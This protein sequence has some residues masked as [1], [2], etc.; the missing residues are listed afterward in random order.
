MEFKDNFQV[1]IIFEMTFFLLNLKEIAVR[2]AKVR[3]LNKMLNNVKQFWTA[4][5]VI[6][7]EYKDSK[8]IFILGNNEDLISKIDDTMLNLNNM[9]GSRFVEEIRS[10][11]EQEMK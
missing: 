6:I 1:L 9:L 10:Q 4:S 8:D 3:E 11:V 7:I 2:A 5:K